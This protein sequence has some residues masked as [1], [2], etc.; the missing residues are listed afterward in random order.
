MNSVQLAAAI[1]RLR[2][3]EWDRYRDRDETLQII[4]AATKGI[5][6]KVQAAENARRDAEFA[7]K[8][9]REENTVKAGMHDQ[10]VWRSSYLREREADPRRFDRA[11]LTG[12]KAL[13]RLYAG[14]HIVPSERAQA[15]AVIT[16]PAAF[17]P[18]AG[19][20]DVCLNS[21]RAVSR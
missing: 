19:S 7:I 16:I 21:Y 9:W 13:K 12:R 17:A 6:A 1:E 11:A 18:A 8:A 2:P 14:L 15:G 10:G 4:V 3:P 20:I 5:Q